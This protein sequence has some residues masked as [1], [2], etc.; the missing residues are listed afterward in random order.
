MNLRRFCY[1]LN[2][3]GRV[4]T[5]NTMVCFGCNSDLAR[6][7]VGLQPR[8][9]IMTTPDAIREHYASTIKRK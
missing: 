7:L 3:I 5:G 9:R 4:G 8:F 6:S 2:V 1:A